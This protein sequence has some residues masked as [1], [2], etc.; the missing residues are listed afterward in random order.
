MHVDPHSPAHHDLVSPS[1]NDPPLRHYK[2]IPN[3][4]LNFK[5]VWCVI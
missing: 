1:F 2:M 4:V 5:R 3:T